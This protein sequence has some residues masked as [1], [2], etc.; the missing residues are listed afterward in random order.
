[1]KKLLKEAGKIPIA[2]VLSIGIPVL[3]KEFV[4]KPI[5][6]QIIGDN[7][8]GQLFQWGGSLLLIWSGYLIYLKLYD[9]KNLFPSKGKSILSDIVLGSLWGVL[10]IGLIAASISI[11]GAF[12][13]ERWVKPTGPFQM[14]LMLLLLVTTEE[15]I[16]RGIL[17]KIFEQW[18]GTAVALTVSS[19]IF[20][21][22]HI[23]N[24]HFNAFSFAAII[25]GGVV[26]SL[27]FSLSGRIYMPVAAHFFWNL[28]QIILGVPLSGTEMFNGLALFQTSLEG[29]VILTGGDFGPENSLAAILYTTAFAFILG[30]FRFSGRTA[31]AAPGKAKQRIRRSRR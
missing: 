28:S 9:K 21:L 11:G 2:L 12:R 23:T 30:Y 16:Y 31:P 3:I 5:R 22:M 8:A 17:H 19:V 29:P 18:F 26:M 10:G 6:M 7:A 25:S 15:I 1:M 24:D 4:L 27:M 20:S 13:I 14:I